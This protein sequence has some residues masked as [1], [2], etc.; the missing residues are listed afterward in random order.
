MRKRGRRTGIATIM[1]TNI[2]FEKFILDI[3]CGID[4]YYKCKKVRDDVRCGLRIKFLN[5]YEIEF[6]NHRL[7]R[8]Y[9]LFKSGEVDFE[10]CFRRICNVID[11][12]LEEHRIKQR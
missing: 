6:D 2:G 10:E 5:G 7:L 3:K 12:G 1:A 4:E 11:R 8:S 9:E